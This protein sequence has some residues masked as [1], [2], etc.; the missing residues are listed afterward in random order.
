MLYDR[1]L[2][3][4]LQPEF[5][6]SKNNIV[7]SKKPIHSEKD[8]NNRNLKELFRSLYNHIMVLL[9]TNNYQFYKMTDL[10]IFYN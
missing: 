3:A 6:G 5:Y 9:S 10:T 2:P 4:I 8:F 7:D 1:Q